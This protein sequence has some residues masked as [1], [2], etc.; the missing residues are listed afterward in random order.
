MALVIKDDF[1]GLRIQFQGDRVQGL[2]HLPKDNEA[3][4]AEKAI[5]AAIGLQ[6]SMQQTLRACLSEM[7]ELQLKVG[8]NLSIT[9]IS[10]LGIRGERDRICLGESVERAAMCEERSE[11]TQIGITRRVLDVPPGELRKHFTYNE[12]AQCYIAS[13]VYKG[14]VRFPL[15]LLISR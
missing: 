6:S 4:I 12:K 14:S 15:S 8:I 5:K 10:R 7:G 11:G 2:F 3:T 1:Q 9:L 13:L